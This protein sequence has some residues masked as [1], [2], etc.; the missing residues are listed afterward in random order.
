MEKVKDWKLNNKIVFT[1]GCFDLLHRG[2]IEYLAQTADCGDKLIVAVN[3]DESVN[4]LNKGVNRPLQDEYSRALIIASLAFVD[5][6]II[7]NEQTPIHLIRDI[8]PSVLVKGGDYDESVSDA[9]DKKYIIGSDFIKKNGGS[10][11]VIPFV[12]GFSTTKIEEKIKNS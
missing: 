2:H 11:E 10:V 8:L 3:S 12:K 9:L 1:N 4:K 7:F 6:V 5:L